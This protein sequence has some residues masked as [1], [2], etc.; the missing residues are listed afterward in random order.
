MKHIAQSLTL[1]L[2]VLAATTVSPRAADWGVGSGGVIKDFGSIKDYKNAAVVPVPSPIPSQSYSKDWYIR[3]DF[4]YNLGTDVDVT[5]VGDIKTRN[6]DDLNGFAFG[7]V[8]FGR[9]ITPSLRADLTF[10]FRPK[11]TVTQGTQT[12][13]KTYTN[14]TTVAGAPPVTTDHTYLYTVSHSDD[15]TTRDNTVFFNLYYDLQKVGRFTPYTGAG[16]GL[17]HKSYKRTTSHSVTCQQ[18]DFDT[19]VGSG[20]ANPTPFA[21]PCAN[22]QPYASPASFSD[23]KYA[24]ELGFAAAVMVGAS[25]EVMAGVQFD[26]GYRLLWEGASV[27]AGTTVFD[28]T[29]TIKI[30]DR[31]DHE[32]HT[33]VRIDLN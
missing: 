24:T 21:G 17:D 18:S 1:G 3:G 26:A 10:D 29:S 12:Y 8:G 32:L 9:Y 25:Y 16:V 14:S 6:S 15:S 5:S 11:K 23:S 20:P 4:G 7:S 30:S 33:G 19:S 31:F 22:T 13:Q 27:S 28:G 2:A